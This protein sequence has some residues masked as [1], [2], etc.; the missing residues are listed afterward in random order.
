MP[1]FV[2]TLIDVYRQHRC[3][4]SEREADV[5]LFLISFH[6]QGRIREAGTGE[7]NFD[8]LKNGTER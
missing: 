4:G 7:L 2:E 8:I 3:W 1:T 6:F 5:F